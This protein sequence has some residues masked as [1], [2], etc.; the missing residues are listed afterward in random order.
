[1]PRPT[2]SSKLGRPFTY[3]SEDERPLT[4]SFRIPRAVYAQVERYL[5]MHPG[6][7]MTE[8]VLD[9]IRLRLDTPTDPRDIILSDDNTVIQELQEM[10]QAAVQKEVG[11]LGAF[12]EPRGSTPGIISAPAAPAKPVPEL[13]HDNNTVIQEGITPVPQMPYDGN[14]VIQESHDMPT[15]D[16]LSERNAAAIAVIDSDAYTFDASKYV[17]G[18]LCTGKHEWGTTGKTLLSIKGRKCKECQTEGQRQRREAKRQAVI[19]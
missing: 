1:M 13:S 19:E 12:L 9:G 16:S 8:F 4:L 10:I 11:K 2:T 6:M 15:T 7:T 5:K 18:K 3:A 17:L 14:S